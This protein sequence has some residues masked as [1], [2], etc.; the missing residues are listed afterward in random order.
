MELVPG[1]SLYRGLFEF[2]QYSFSGDS[3]GTSGMKWGDLDDSQNGMKAVLII[4][5]VEWLVLLVVAFYLDQVIGGGI[6]KDPIF[7]LR[8]FRKKSSVSQRKPSFQ[9]QGSKVFVE[10]ERPDVSQEVSCTICQH[11]QSTILLCSVF[12]Y[13]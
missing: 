5:F 7:F 10:M 13:E 12:I 2:S 9:R 11:C 8:Y 3:M 1:F 4:M 6:R